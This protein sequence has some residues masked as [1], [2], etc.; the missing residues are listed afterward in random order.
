MVSDQVGKVAHD[1]EIRVGLR[2]ICEH[3]IDFVDCQHKHHD[4]WVKGRPYLPGQACP[5]LP[6]ASTLVSYPGVGR[7]SE[8]SSRRRSRPD[9][10]ELSVRHG[11]HL[12][13]LLQRAFPADWRLHHGCTPDERL[14]VCLESHD[15][16]SRR[17]LLREVHGHLDRDLCE[18]QF[19]DLVAFELGSHL[20]PAEMGL[21]AREFLEWVGRRIAAGADPAPDGPF[22]APPSGGAGDDRDEAGHAG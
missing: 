20:H 3:I 15:H 2:T 4:N 22:S 17:R 16:T 18:M 7:R 6:S 1:G 14:R 9:R 8:S 11:S 10:S 13:Q 21:A 12:A 5:H 19:S